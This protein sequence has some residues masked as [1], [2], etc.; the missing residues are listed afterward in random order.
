MQVISFVVQVI[1]RLQPNG[2]GKLHA[3]PAPSLKDNSLTSRRALLTGGVA[4]AGG[5]HIGRFRC[6]GGGHVCK[7]RRFQQHQC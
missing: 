2:R 4:L 5:F 6:L 7:A 1:R 3:N